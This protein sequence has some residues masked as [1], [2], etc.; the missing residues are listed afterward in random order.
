MLDDMGSNEEADKLRKRRRQLSRGNPC[1]RDEERATRHAS[2]RSSP[3]ACWPTS[4]AHDPLTATRK[5]SYYDLMCP[6]IIGSEIFG[7]G[8]D[9]ED[10]ADRLSASSTAASRWA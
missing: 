10:V 7:Q 8:S 5:G 3:S 4:A 1:G 9:R 6:Y 2:H